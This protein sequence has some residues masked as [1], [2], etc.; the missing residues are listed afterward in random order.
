M[1]FLTRSATGYSTW[2]L[3]ADQLRS[4]IVDGSFA[5]ETKMPTEGELADR[6][7]VHRNTIRQSIAVLV[8]EGLVARRQGSGTFVVPHTLLVHRIG[9]R[10]RL[11]NSARQPDATSNRP[12]ASE[13]VA[14]PPQEVASRLRLEGRP[15]LQIETVA[16]VN[17][18]T[19]AR[20]TAWF[21]VAL[22]PDLDVHLRQ[23]RSVTKALRAV[24][25]DDYVRTWSAVSARIANRVEAEDMNLPSGSIVLVVRSVN[26]LLDGTPLQ[27]TSTRFRADRVELDIDFSDLA[28][29]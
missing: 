24:G 15:A 25:I 16:D 8:E 22:T 21:D 14:N 29:H 1:T 28:G 2:R 20:S 9:L 19:I 10:T 17:G 4:E 23:T 5:P 18:T 13:I 27:Y 12:I 3:I 11:S 6:F 26:S 7:G